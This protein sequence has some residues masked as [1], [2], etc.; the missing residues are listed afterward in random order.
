MIPYSYTITAQAIIV[1]SIAIPTFISLNII[2]LT[3][4]RQNIFYLIL[5]AGAPIFLT[6]AIAILELISYFIR[7][8]SLTLR[9]S[10]NMIAGHILM[11]ILLYAIISTPL[12]SIVLLPIILLEL[13][14]ALLQAYVFVILITS[15]YQDIM[16]PH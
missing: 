13:L 7:P 11:K 3:Y 4:H 10:A 16:L 14:V 12:L 2:G 6:P 1:F 8:L 5:P 15:Y 9:L